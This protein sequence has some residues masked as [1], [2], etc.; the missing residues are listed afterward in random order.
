MEAVVQGHR[1]QTL[2]FRQRQYYQEGGVLLHIKQKKA[3]AAAPETRH[4]HDRRLETPSAKVASA[5]EFVVHA[6]HRMAGDR[7]TLSQR[8]FAP[9]TGCHLSCPACSM[10]I[11]REP[12]RHRDHAPTA[13]PDN[14]IR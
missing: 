5:D 1:F 6:A 11:T 12:A 10:R 8:S 4:I 13:C 3:L 9:G 14:P 7:V 2:A